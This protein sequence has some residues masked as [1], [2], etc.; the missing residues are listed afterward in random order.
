MGLKED[1]YFIALSVIAL[2]FVVFWSSVSIHRY[3]TF[4]DQYW[5]MGVVMYNF[6][7][8]IHGLALYPNFLYYLVSMNHM[9]FLVLLLYPIFAIFPNA[10]TLFVI[11]ATALALTAI[12]A[13]FVCVSLL[14]SRKIGFTI[15]LAFMVNPATLGLLA[16]DFHLEAFTALFY[17]LSFYYYIKRKKYHFVASY[18][19]LLGVL[20]VETAVGA[21]LLLGLLIYELFYNL[22]SKGE[23]RSNLKTGLVMLLIG[24]ALTAVFYA[25]YT[26]AAAYVINNYGSVPYTSI[27]PLQRLTNFLSQQ[28]SGLSGHSGTS[29]NGSTFVYASI[30]GLFVFLYSFGPAPLANL[31]ISLILYSPWLVEL[32]VIHNPW[33][34]FPFSQDYSYAL[35]ASLVSAILGYLI[36]SE[37]KLKLLN[38]KVLDTKRFK[39]TY[40]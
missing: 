8:H 34:I 2:I 38:L 27:T 7:W 25:F 37:G 11:Q 5:D 30:L 3:A 39:T 18:A 1:K 15:A 35:G 32:V 17:I 20:E 36:L 33:F 22:R 26:Q 12:L 14:K 16:S 31:L 40:H 23:A 21:T 28:I 19:M 9:S 6:Y 29:F 10:L 13:Y 4:S 24:F